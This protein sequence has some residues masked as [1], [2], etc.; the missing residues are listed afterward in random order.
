M[1]TFAGMLI[2]V[3]RR[4]RIAV[5]PRDVVARVGGDEFGVLLTGI[6]S[7]SDADAVARRILDA[8]GR[9]FALAGAPVVVGVS[10]GIAFG[11]DA[12][13]PTALMHDAD[14]AMFGAKDHGKGR[15]ERHRRQPLAAPA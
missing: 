4:L 1:T 3:G 14:L 5:R 10:I 13:T 9:P 7:R 2:E 11:T 15:F 8:F 6:S 12:T